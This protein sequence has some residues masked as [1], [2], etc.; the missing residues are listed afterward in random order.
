MAKFK[1]AEQRKIKG[2]FVC[3]RCKAKQRTSPIKVVLKSV[4]CRSC[5]GK[6]FRALR[7]I[8]VSGK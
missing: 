6:S 5:G 7:K 3:K 8:K 2:I 4:K 1:E